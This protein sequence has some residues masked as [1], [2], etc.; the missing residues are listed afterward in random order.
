[1]RVFSYAC[2]IVVCRATAFQYGGWQSEQYTATLRETAR[3]KGSALRL[4]ADEY[5]NNYRV[6]RCG[7]AAATGCP[8]KSAACI[9]ERWTARGY[10]QSWRLR[11]SGRE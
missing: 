9:R 4:I 7:T 11:G 2:L 8:E 3:D 6:F 5:D 10:G 1:M